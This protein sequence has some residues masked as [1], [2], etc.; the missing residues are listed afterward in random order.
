MSLH[1][2]I[3][4]VEF[5]YC[6][7]IT[8]CYCCRN[9]SYVGTRLDSCVNKYLFLHFRKEDNFIRHTSSDV[10]KGQRDHLENKRTEEQTKTQTN[11]QTRQQQHSHVSPGDRKLSSTYPST[12]Y[13]HTIPSDDREGQAQL[14]RLRQG[15]SPPLPT[16]PPSLALHT[17]GKEN[18]RTDLLPSPSSSHLLLLGLPTLA[19]RRELTRS[20]VPCTAPPGPPPWRACCGVNF[21]VQLRAWAA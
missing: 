6:F 8:L 9:R 21:H 17:A 11:R 15:T 14:P 19:S 10:R 2:Q 12:L 3:A 7:I 4:W 13:P 20:V 5:I 1:V 16:N 18:C